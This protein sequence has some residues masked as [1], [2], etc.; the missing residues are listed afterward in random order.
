MPPQALAHLQQG[1][2]ELVEMYLHHASKLLSKIHH[3]TDIAQIPVG[4][5]NH[6]TVV[7]G[8]NSTKLKEKS[9]GHRHAYRNTMEDCISNIHAFGAGYERAKGYP[10]VDVNTPEPTISE[11]QSKKNHDHASNVVDHIFRADA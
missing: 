9:A 7:Y 2:D 11:I 8:P 10:R 3:I 1:P 5:L 6:H 4:G